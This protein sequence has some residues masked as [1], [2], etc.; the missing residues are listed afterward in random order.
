MFSKPTVF[1]VGAGGSKEVNLPVGDELKRIIATKLNLPDLNEAT[2]SGDV[3]IRNALARRSKDEGDYKGR[4]TNYITSAQAI[5]SAMPQAISIDNYLHTHSADSYIV[6]A[7]KLGIAASIL[8][9]EQRSRIYGMDNG[10]TFINFNDSADTWFNTFCKMLTEN[11]RRDNLDTIFDN[12]TFVTF[13]YDRC[14]EHYVM[15]WLT[16]YMRLS[17]EDGY[18]LA[19]RLK[20]YHPYGQ[21]CRLPWQDEDHSVEFGANVE[22]YTVAYAASQIRTFTERVEDDAMLGAMRRVI[23]E[24]ELVVYMGFSFGQMN[25]DLLAIEQNGAR[26]KVLATAM[27]ISEPNKGQVLGRI[28]KSLYHGGQSLVDSH[29]L[30]GV[31]AN[32]LLCDYWYEISS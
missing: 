14:I 28:Y 10:K 21:V 15:L 9:A 8:E 26:K 18:A 25:M 1:I 27:G 30:H 13:N 23:S 12:V 4:M 24:A 16:N 17:R 5:R 3:A 32:Q 2:G 20:V 6:T 11:V 22:E 7:G 29:N 19:S 31:T